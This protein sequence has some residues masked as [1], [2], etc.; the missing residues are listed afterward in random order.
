MVDTP[1]AIDRETGILYINMKLYGELTPFEKRFVKLHEYGHYNLK[2]SDEIAADAY[3]FD[4]LV[5]TEKYS[6]NQMGQLLEDKILDPSKPGHAARISALRLRAEKWLREHPDKTTNDQKIIKS[7]SDFYMQMHD[8]MNMTIQTYNQGN[9]NNSNTM[10]FGIL[11]IAVVMMIV[12][13]DK[14]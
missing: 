7:L 9:Q 2:T 8:S 14:D 10:V 6:I 13:T 3:A 4:Q 5:G 12:L 1:A 11:G